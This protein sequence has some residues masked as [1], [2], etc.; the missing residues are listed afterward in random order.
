MT[1]VEEERIR[2]LMEELDRL[3]PKDGAYI[4]LEQYGG[5][6]DEGRIVANQAGYLRFGIEFL[7]A[8]VMPHRPSK[9]GQSSVAID[10]TY[11]VTADS[12]I[13]FDEF[14]RDERPPETEPQRS[15]LNWVRMALGFGFIAGCI[16]VVIFAVVGVIAVIRQQ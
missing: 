6:P 7:K 8:G 9:S 1:T 5:G 10:L 15:A 13:G 2:Q 11:L 16:V 3:A 12:V 4:R 14:I